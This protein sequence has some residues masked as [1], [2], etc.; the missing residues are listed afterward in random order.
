MRNTIVFLILLSSFFAKSDIHMAVVK[1]Q[2][3]S[4][5]DWKDEKIQSS[6][7]QLISSKQKLESLKDK[8][9][10]KNDGLIKTLEQQISQDEWNLEVTESLSVRDYVILYLANQQGTDKFQNAA[11]KMG[12]KETAQL[13]EAYADVIQNQKQNEFHSKLPRAS[14][15]DNN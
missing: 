6:K 1:P 3:K 11:Q 9:K 7:E 4:F 8:L 13:L 2:L 15:E 5:G 12:P 14:N 10:N